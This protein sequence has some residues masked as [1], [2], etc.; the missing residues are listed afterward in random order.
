[1]LAIL[2][3]NSLESDKYVEQQKQAN[4][5]IEQG[6]TNAPLKPEQLTELVLSPA[7]SVIP[8]KF[9]EH[10]PTSLLNTPLP[11]LLDVNQDGSLLINKKILHLFEFYLSAIGEE[12]LELIVTR[13]K[14]N[15]KAQLKA[16]ALDEAL[17]ILEGYLQ[18]RNEITALKQEYNQAAGINEYSL[19]H[20]INARNE[21]IETR[22]RFL[23]G[24]VI[25]AFFEQEDEYENYML[26]LATIIRDNSLSQVQKE[27]AISQLN[28]QAPSWLIEQQN[29]A[30]Q[31][32]KYRLK[33]NE[34]VSLGASD[35]ELR[36]LREQEFNVEVSDRLSTLDAQRLRW[37]Q[38][39]SEYRVDLDTILAIEPDR[40]AQ[41][42]LIDELRSQHFNSQEIRRVSALDRRYL[43]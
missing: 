29:T 34:L 24:D 30:N 15:L 35:S 27:N 1:M 42:G 16:Q 25:A 43:N 21:L 5:L 9:T 39:L 26:S 11:E 18:Y 37:Q 23:S 12:S 7:N 22:W 3:F 13:I 38:R 36:I 41:Q 4:T 33:Y 2:L 31:L 8:L 28:T 17:H 40:K 14:S 32:N 10:L 6:V 20:V 19:E